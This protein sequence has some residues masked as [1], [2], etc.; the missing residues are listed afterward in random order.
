MF[1]RTGLRSIAGLAWVLGLCALVALGTS[2]GATAG[3]AATAAA[4]AARHGSARPTI[5]AAHFRI[6]RSGS[7]RILTIVALVDHATRCDVTS[8]R[9]AG[10]RPRGVSCPAK[11]HAVEAKI[12]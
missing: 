5:H 10:K 12:S 11:G 6:T 2:T 7:G 4:V 3:S 9:I 8:K 1:A